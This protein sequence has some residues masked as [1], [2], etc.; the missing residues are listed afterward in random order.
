ME[1]KLAV[2]LLSALAQD[3]RLAI[4]RL[5]VQAGPSGVS[6]GEIGAAVKAPPAT[7]SFHLKELAHA[8]LVTARQQSRYIFYSANYQRMSELLAFLTE[9]CCA[10]DG[11]TCDGVCAPSARPVIKRPIAKGRSSARRRARSI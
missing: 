9:N 4:F 8:E 5:L 3:T 2:G 1:S 7:V 6:A 10:A 11:L